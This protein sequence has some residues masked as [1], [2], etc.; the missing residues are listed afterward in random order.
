MGIM[1]P[2]RLC[3]RIKTMKRFFYGIII[4]RDNIIKNINNIHKKWGEFK[5]LLI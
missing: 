2:C 3:N 5:W 1:F 4:L